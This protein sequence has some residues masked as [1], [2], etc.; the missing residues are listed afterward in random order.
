MYFEF[1][2]NLA[3]NLPRMGIIAKQKKK[4][5][6]AIYPKIAYGAYPGTIES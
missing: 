1:W 5:T 2:I 6:E 3:S 4:L